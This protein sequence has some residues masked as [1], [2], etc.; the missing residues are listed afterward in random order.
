MDGDLIIDLVGLV[1]DGCGTSEQAGI[2]L[3]Y[4]ASLVGMECQLGI[5]SPQKNSLLPPGVGSAQNHELPRQCAGASC[6]KSE[7]ACLPRVLM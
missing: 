5:S 7:L 3:R 2:L 4:Y 1:E 6:P